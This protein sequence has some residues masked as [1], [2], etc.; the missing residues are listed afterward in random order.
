M[1]FKFFLYKYRFFFGYIII[2]ILS[3]IIEIIFFKFLN[4]FSN[5]PIINSFCS[6]I[7][8]IIFSFW[9][10]VRYNFKISKSKRNR[11][12]IY[13]LVISFSSYLIQIFIIN[14]FEIYMQYEKL[15]I[16]TSGS[17][18]WLAYLF[19]R[20]FS[21]RD[22]KKV[23]VAIYANG[24]E[25]LK[26]I[27]KK[28]ENYPDFIHIDIVDETF[29]KNAKQVLTYKTEVV[30]GYWNSKFIEV[31]IMSK[32]PKKWI[33]DIVQNVDRVIIHCNINESIEELLKLIRLNNC[34][35]GIVVHE[36]DHIEIF[37]KYHYLIDSILV[38]SIE[39]PGYSGQSFK[40]KALEIISKIN[41]HKYRNQISLIVDGGINNKN[42][43]LVKSENIVSG[44]YVLN[45]EDPI[46][47]IMIL[48]TS[49]QYES[50]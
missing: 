7:L 50:I 47:N 12:L 17:I 30:R 1:N 33:L 4:G 11:S 44:S 29:S 21:F 49:S 31:H 42:I 13:F 41:K 26:T 19:H 16:I 46:K 18:F 2:G 43:S 36:M 14:R 6:V 40:M 28:V 23:G 8:G 15:R 3:L 34:K 25:D 20:K 5:R 10:N 35:T 38:L 32:R 39:N 48:Q 45:A 22:F 24:V 27:F 37:E 9:F